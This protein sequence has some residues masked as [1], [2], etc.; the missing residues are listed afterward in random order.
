[1]H[2]LERNMKKLHKVRELLTLPE[3]AHRLAGR[4]Q[5]EVTEEDVLRL[6]LEGHLTLSVKFLKP[7]RGRLGRV[8]SEA[9]ATRSVT[10]EVF[11]Y[12]L[13]EVPHAARGSGS[14]LVVKVDAD[15]YL[16][17]M[18]EISTIDGIWDLP[19]VGNERVEIERRIR[20]LTGKPDISPDSA[21]GFFLHRE[22][23]EACQL[24]ESLRGHDIPADRLPGECELMIRTGALRECVARIEAEA[25]PPKPRDNLAARAETTYL[26]IIGGLVNLMLGKNSLGK[27]QSVFRTQSA[28]IA[29]LTAQYPDKHGLSERTLEDKFA[30]AKESL[31]SS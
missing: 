26:N 20:R 6:A 29:T 11:I 7:A 19:L 12:G 31:E 1:M 8:V 2:N 5:E 3:A 17:L 9:E 16:K 27:A 22:S 23:G 15:R 14:P 25:E 24:F 13:S 4:L 18:G 30:A 28:I 21:E 10:D